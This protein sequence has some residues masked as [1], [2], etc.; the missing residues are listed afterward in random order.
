MNAPIDAPDWRSLSQD[1]RDAGFNNSNAVADSPAILSGWERLSADMRARYSQHLDLRYGPRERNRIDFLNA[2]VKGPT[3][4]FIHGGYWQ[5]RAKETFTFCAAGPMAHGINVAFV[6]YTLAPDATL[7]EIVSQVRTSIDFLATE[8]AALGGDPDRIIVSGWSAGGHLSSMMLGHPRIKA[9]LLISGIYDLEPIQYTYLNEK[10]R[11]DKAMADRNS[12]I[13]QPGG[14]D[15][16]VAIIA[17]SS[18]LPLLRK[19][20]ADFAAHRARHGLPVVYEEIPGANHFT[21]MDALSSPSGR[22]TTL[23]RQLAERITGPR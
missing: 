2:G 4:V 7:D 18:E 11:L 3:L 20:S 10:L 16:P 9:G 21:I 23:V 14:A 22:M 13:K 12:P 1:D 6:G 15:K 19:Q 8:L 17:G 5:A